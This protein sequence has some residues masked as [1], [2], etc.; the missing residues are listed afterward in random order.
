MLHS[1]ELTSPWPNSHARP[2][3]SASTEILNRFRLLPP[4]HGASHSDNPVQFPSVG[5][6]GYC[7]PCHRMPFRSTNEDV[8]CAMGRRQGVDREYVGCR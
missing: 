8:E 1:N 7:S 2:P 4:P 5:I 6:V 3:L